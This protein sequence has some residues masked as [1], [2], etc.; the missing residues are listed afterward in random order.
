MSGIKLSGQAI[1]LIIALVILT[2]IS[3]VGPDGSV[4]Q[5]DR[6]ASYEENELI[7]GTIS[8]LC[9]YDSWVCNADAN[10][11]IDFIILEH[12]PF[13]RWI[14]LLID[15]PS[16]FANK[17]GSRPIIAIDKSTLFDE[18]KRPV[19]LYHELM[20]LKMSRYNEYSGQDAQGECKDHNLVKLRT[21]EFYLKLSHMEPRFLSSA[22]YALTSSGNKEVLCEEL[23]D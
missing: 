19:V 7:Q 21:Q 18:A 16:A 8:T 6:E 11:K 12:S 13:R 3:C 4:F 10:N 15:D 1:S 2:V 14:G 9:K 17:S 22:Q 5:G 20:H 23:A